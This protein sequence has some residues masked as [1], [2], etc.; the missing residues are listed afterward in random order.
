MTREI[1]R[2]RLS[3]LGYSA[4]LIQEL[5][6]V[7]SPGNVSFMSIAGCRRVL[8]RLLKD[9]VQLCQKEYSWVPGF[10]GNWQRTA[11]LW[12]YLT[13][14]VNILTTPESDFIKGFFS[15]LCDAGAHAGMSRFDPHLSSEILWYLADRC[16]DGMTK[17]GHSS[18][19]NVQAE[20]IPRGSPKSP[21]ALRAL[22]K[23]FL[24]TLRAG[25]YSHPDAHIQLTSDLSQQLRELVRKDDSD[26]FWR[27]VQDESAPQ[28][29]R[30]QLASNMLS[31]CF[32]NDLEVK[33]RLIAEMRKYY[34][35]HANET[36]EKWLV[37]RAIALAIANRGRDPSC[38]ADFISRIKELNL[39]E[40]NLRVTDKYKEGIDRAIDSYVQMLN[41]RL[42]ETPSPAYVWELFYLGRRGN[43]QDRELVALIER[44]NDRSAHGVVK[45]FCLEALESLRQRATASRRQ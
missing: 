29:L 19:P 2:D 25:D 27:I 44:C 36:R 30:N 21:Q 33:A 28:G 40:E 38:I 26:R 6:S 23:R 22:A 37:L 11:D 45:R 12:R 24:A 43:P 32:K 34:F 20:D 16:S 31:Y 3:A 14:S 35:A 18:R 5:Q 42:D 9:T 7:S 17:L 41:K 4:T 8:E 1:V 10:K 15:L 13:S 39:I